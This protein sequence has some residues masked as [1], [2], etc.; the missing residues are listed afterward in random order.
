MLRFGTKTPGALKKLVKTEPNKYIDLVKAVKSV[1]DYKNLKAGEEPEVFMWDIPW[2]SGGVEAS[3]FYGLQ[4]F[5][6][7]WDGTE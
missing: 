4:N 7:L 3:L 2:G 1:R 5:N 6:A